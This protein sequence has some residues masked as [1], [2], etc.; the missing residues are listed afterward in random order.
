MRLRYLLL[1]AV[2]GLTFPN[3]ASA[4]VTKYL[5]TTTADSLVGFDEAYHS[6]AAKAEGLSGNYFIE[7]MSGQQ[8]AYINEKYYLGEHFAVSPPA[9]NYFKPLGGTGFVN[10]APCVN[11]DFENSTSGSFAGWT[12]YRGRNTASN[13]IPTYTASNLG[14]GAQVSVVT[15]PY[16]DNIVGTIPNSPL[17]GSKVIRLNN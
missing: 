8:R 5:L 15:T 16:S 13:V 14:V 11:E 4:Q 6:A 7:Y 2:I 1:S 17:G 3:V 9:M 12:A 10:N